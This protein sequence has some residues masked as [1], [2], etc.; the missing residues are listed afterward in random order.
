[1]ALK[2]VARHA[3]Q[4]LADMS[5]MVIEDNL[6]MRATMKSMLTGMEVTQ[7][8]F[9]QRAAEARKK[10]VARPCDL[11]L[12]DYMLDPDGMNGQE[13]LEELR[14]TQS[15]PLHTI[16]III[17]AERV[18]EKVVAA[19]EYG[20]DDYIIKPFAPDLLRL[21]LFRAIERKQAMT[22]VNRALAAR[23]PITAL[24]A[25]EKGLVLHPRFSVDFLRVKAEVLQTLNRHEEARQLYEDI[26]KHKAVPWARFGLAQLMARAEQLEAA[27]AEFAGLVEE[28]P[29]FLRAYDSLS[30]VQR[31]RGDHTAAQATLQKAADK[32]NSLARLAELGELAR[33]N[34]DL[35]TAE[36]ILTRT[37]ARAGVSELVSADHVLAL[38]AVKQ[39]LGKSDEALAVLAGAKKSMPGGVMSL[40]SMVVEARI[41][42]Q[43]QNMEHA[44]RQLDQALNLIEQ[45]RLSISAELAPELVHACLLTGHP[46]AFRMAQTVLEQ[47][48]DDR[49]RA[50]IE[51]LLTNFGYGQ[52]FDALSEEATRAVT[53][54][55]NEGV[56]AASRGDYAT[57][58]DLLSD[59]YQRMPGNARVG[60]NLSKI[61]VAALGE[62][63]APP[64]YIRQAE[65]ILAQLFTLPD[66]S[67]REQAQQIRQRLVSLLTQRGWKP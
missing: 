3:S 4:S 60:I 39:E 21:R 45:D 1:M 13:L 20:P 8:D 41:Y 65:D 42:A 33:N 46:D 64:Q 37:V 28:N 32:S 66:K 27:E 6:A 31:S 43:K 55:N 52:Q 17:T 35:A 19:A 47:H 62:G 29:L 30:R 50:E 18:Y 12:C 67:A 61:L 56:Q 48:S 38:A 15:L 11:V 5:V 10:L 9:A 23:D 53:R 7:I 2:P 25:C 49:L 36:S 57:A 59:A 63:K 14:L 34:G 40:T 26:L 58:V 44:R 54:I 16:F 51:R 22:E 24:A